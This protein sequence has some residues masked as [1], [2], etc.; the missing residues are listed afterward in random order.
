MTPSRSTSQAHGCG[1]IYI[2]NAK[3]GGFLKVSVN[4]IAKNPIG[5][6]IIPMYTFY[7]SWYVNGSQ[8]ETTPVNADQ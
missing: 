2:H 3:Y 1:G 6:I 8:R 5:K 7:L 4:K